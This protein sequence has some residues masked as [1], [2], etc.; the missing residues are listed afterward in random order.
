MVGRRRH[1]LRSLSLPNRKTI[2]HPSHH[3]R[4]PT[5]TRPRRSR[6]GC[7]PQKHSATPS[8]AR[9]RCSTGTRRRDRR[10]TTPGCCKGGSAS[11]LTGATRTWV[12][13]VALARA[14]WI[15]DGGECG[16]CLAGH[17]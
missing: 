9:P 5:T 16:N 11:A 3:Q 1:G 4:T 13:A 10:S 2:T 12:T 17:A 7:E 8:R 14:Q 15:G 6:P